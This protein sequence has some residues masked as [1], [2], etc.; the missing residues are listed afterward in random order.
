MEV[1]DEAAPSIHTVRDVWEANLDP[2][3]GPFK[4]ACWSLV[5]VDLMAYL[6]ENKCR[7]VRDALISFVIA[8]C[9]SHALAKLFPVV[10]FGQLPQITGFLCIGMLVGPF[11]CNLVTHMHIFMMGQYINRVSLAF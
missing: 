2:S 6:L 11:C 4:L 9:A 7:D 5:E 1:L 3:M 10:S 8:S